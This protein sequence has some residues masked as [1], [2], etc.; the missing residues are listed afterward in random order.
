MICLGMDERRRVSILG[1][2]DRLRT[3]ETLLG[4][5]WPFGGTVLTRSKRTLFSLGTA[6]RQE[7]RSV[8][9]KRQ[10]KAGKKWRAQDEGKKNEGNAR[11]DL[12]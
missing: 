9:Q 4:P 5:L 2:Q 3:A 6:R 10:I 8:V 11:F 7:D 1:T 12:C